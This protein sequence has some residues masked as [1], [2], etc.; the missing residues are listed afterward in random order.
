MYFYGAA[1]TKSQHEIQFR[2]D[3]LNKNVTVMNINIAPKLE[4]SV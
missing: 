2:R 4:L 1:L 3:L